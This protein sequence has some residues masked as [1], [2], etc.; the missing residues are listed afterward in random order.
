M[1]FESWDKSGVL[2]CFW[3]KIGYFGHIFWDMDF[4]FVLFTIHINIKGEI[5]LEVNWIQIDYFMQNRRADNFGV[6]GCQNRIKNDGVMPIENWGKSGVLA[7]FLLK[8]G[9][10]GHIFW[11]MDFKF[12]LLTIHINIK[13]ET[14]LE[15]NWIQIDHFIL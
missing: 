6:V 4:K 7:C 5:Q 13:E 9:Y 3:L 15:V 14:Q 11:D 8:I 10:F 12:V 2:A 1:P